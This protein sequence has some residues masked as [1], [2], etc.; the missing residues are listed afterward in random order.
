MLALPLLVH[1]ITGL[2]CLS[3]Y[4]HRSLSIHSRS[5]LWQC[6]STACNRRHPRR[7]TEAD[8]IAD[9]FLEAI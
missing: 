6:I 8:F 1:P 9:K 7:A 2:Y 5:Y 3:V 4:F